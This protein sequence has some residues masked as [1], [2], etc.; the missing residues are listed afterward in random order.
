MAPDRESKQ[1]ARMDR[2]LRKHGGNISAV[3]R[4][5]SKRGKSISRQAV[6]RQV[7][8]LGL[9][10]VAAEIGTKNGVPGRRSGRVDLTATRDDERERILTAIARHGSYRMAA[11]KIPMPLRTLMRR[12]A[13][14]EIRAEEIAARRGALAAK[15]PARAV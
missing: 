10:R 15:K 5:L 3:A 13:S 14:Y 7:A 2:L 9:E 4:A 1:R 11:P 6:A 12:I 8:H